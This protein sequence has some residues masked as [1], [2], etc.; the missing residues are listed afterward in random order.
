MSRG[1]LDMDEVTIELSESELEEIDDI[2]F[3]DHRGNRE[4]A[5][6]DLLDEWLKSREE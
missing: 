1:A 2:A 5:I 3:T 4:A 6:R